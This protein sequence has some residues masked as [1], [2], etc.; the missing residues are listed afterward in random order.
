[1]QSEAGTINWVVPA[2]GVYRI[3]RLDSIG[4]TSLKFA[5]PDEFAWPTSAGGAR[6]HAGGLR[7]PRHHLNASIRPPCGTACQESGGALVPGI[8]TVC[9]HLPLASRRSGLPHQPR[10]ADSRTRCN[11]RRACPSGTPV[12]LPS[13]PA[14]SR[15][16]LAAFP[17]VTKSRSA[18]Q[19]LHSH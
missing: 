13:A 10:A 6:Y 18:L 7:R 19:P 9:A 14:A 8:A 3:V 16:N 15:L 2:E 11:R 4:L 17:S 5:I 1:M 12:L